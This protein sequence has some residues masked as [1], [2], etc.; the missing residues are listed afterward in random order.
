MTFK[1]TYATPDIRVVYFDPE[2]PLCTSGNAGSLTI[3]DE[4]DLV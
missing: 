3:V 4:D 2:G 1:N